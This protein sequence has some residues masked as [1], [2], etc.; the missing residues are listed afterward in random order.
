MAKPVINMRSS[1]NKVKGQGVGACYDEMVGLLKARLDNFIV[2]ENYHGHSD[3][4]HYHT[5]DP[6]FYVERKTK[7]KKIVAVGYV[8]FLPETVDESLNLPGPA[9]WF[10]YKYVLKFYNSMDY[11][12][13][14]NPVF[15]PKIRQ[16]GIDKPQVLCIPNFVSEKNFY[17][18]EE[19]ERIKIRKKYNIGEKD[20]VV[21]G[22]GQLQTR[23]GIF[24]FVKTAKLLPDVTFVWAGGFSFGKITDG[25]DEIKALTQNPPPNVKFIGLVPREEMNGLYNMSDLMFLPSFDELFPMAILEALSCKKPILLR[26]IELYK[27]ILFEYYLKGTSPD[28]FAAQIRMIQDLG[29]TYQE[30]ADKSWQCHNIYSETGVLKM[31]DEF[32]TSILEEK[33]SRDNNAI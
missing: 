29:P 19:S 16:S 10:F 31:W 2:K 12:V 33:R 26:D 1:A 8:H 17:P 28:S 14:V 32:Y 7:G 4:I 23:K 18:M 25:Y 30:F 20:F 24:D 21:M 15:V 22:A 5:V 11:L 6:N 13:T 3:I 9:R 27:D